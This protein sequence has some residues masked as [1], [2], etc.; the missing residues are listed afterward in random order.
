MKKYIGQVIHQFLEGVI[1]DGKINLLM[2]DGEESDTTLMPF[3]GYQRYDAPSV[4]NYA[5]FTTSFENPTY[6]EQCRE[7]HGEMNLGPHSQGIRP[8]F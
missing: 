4:R 1:S 2:H 5:K 8:H 7:S 6:G 3:Y